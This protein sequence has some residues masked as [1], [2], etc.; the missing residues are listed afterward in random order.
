MVAAT[1]LAIFFVP[2]FFVVMLR[3]FRVKPRKIEETAPESQ[4]TKPSDQSRI[5]AELQQQ[6]NKLYERVGLPIPRKPN[7][8]D[9][10][11][12]FDRVQEHPD[13]ETTL[14]KNGK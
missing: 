14:H 1:I 10:D 8:S 3:F 7:N 5:N 2:I 9:D 11:S 12:S 6:L 13:V 4:E